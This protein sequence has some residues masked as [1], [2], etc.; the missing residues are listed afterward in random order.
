MTIRADGSHALFNPTGQ[1]KSARTELLDLKF[2]HELNVS[3]I[4]ATN[5]ILA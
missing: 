3:S 1:V 4:Y 2:T 5:Q